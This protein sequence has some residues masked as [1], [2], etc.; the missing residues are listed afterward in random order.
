MAIS[1]P[2]ES[3]WALPRGNDRYL[4]K[5]CGHS[6]MTAVSKANRENFIYLILRHV[7]IVPD[8]TIDLLEDN[9]HENSLIDYRTYTHRANKSLCRYVRFRS[10]VDRIDTE[11]QYTEIREIIRPAIDASVLWTYAY[12]TDPYRSQG[13]DPSDINDHIAEKLYLY[14]PF[15]LKL[16]PS[17]ETL[18]IHI[19]REM[20]GTRKSEI[21]AVIDEEIVKMKKLKKLLDQ[22]IEAADKTEGQ[23]DGALTRTSSS[24][25]H[26][27]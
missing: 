3:G 16:C 5:F 20:T 18:R 23:K 10:M 22:S 12:L 4:L 15:I 9:E 11:G 7:L 19:A 26:D 6:D 8:T 13:E 27:N 21:K 14:V 24:S 1:H 25:T 17:V 2:S